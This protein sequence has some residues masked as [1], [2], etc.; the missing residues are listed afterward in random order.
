[1]K[2]KPDEWL[3]DPSFKAYFVLDP[4][5]WD[6]TNFT[7]SWNEAITKEEMNNRLMRSTL[8]IKVTK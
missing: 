3:K 2:K 8:S 7:E 1:M 5:G 6:R 4:D